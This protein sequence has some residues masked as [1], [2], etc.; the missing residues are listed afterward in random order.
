MYH[1]MSDYNI[2][3]IDPDILSMVLSNLESV[4]LLVAT[5]VNRSFNNSRRTVKKKI[6]IHIPDA[7]TSLDRLQWVVK[8]STKSTWQKIQTC[9]YAAKYNN[10]EILKWLHEQGCSIGKANICSDAA[11]NGNLEMLK[12]ARENECPWDEKTCT[13][14]ARSGHLDILKWA[15]KNECPWSAWTCSQAASC[16]GIR[17]F[18]M[19]LEKWV[20]IG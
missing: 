20:S 2:N 7:Y 15:R 14:A 4:D 12:W 18:G 8:I 10:L 9:K 17:C 6:K 19:D 5:H 3:N 13:S 1:D 11:R 16:F